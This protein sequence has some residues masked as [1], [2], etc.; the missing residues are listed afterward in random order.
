M[1]T[2]ITAVGVLLGVL[3]LRG[4]QK[5]RMRQF[6]S[7][8][9]DRYWLLMDQ[10]SLEAARGR[11][12]PDVRED[13]EKVV[14]SYIRLCEDE[15]EL[16]HDA[17]IGDATWKIWS[18]GMRAQFKHWPFAPVWELVC[19]EDEQQY[20]YLRGVL[21]NDERALTPARWRRFAS[22]LAGQSRV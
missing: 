7:F 16:R 4:S 2:L 20:E 22:V 19:Q 21:R 17:W 3:T 13:D 12:L 15:C 1:A 8:Y 11:K 18:D 14:R 5:Q 10:L 9:V 6:E